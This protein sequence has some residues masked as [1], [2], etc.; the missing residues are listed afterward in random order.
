MSPPV[1]A[2]EVRGV[3]RF[4]A[5]PEAVFDAWLDP[6]AVGRWL[7]ATPTG[8]METVELDPRVGG[9]FTVSERRGDV[10]AE[11]FGTFVELDRPRRLVFDFATGRDQPLTR[12]TVDI[13][14][15]AGGCELTLSHRL[16]PAWAAYLDRARAGWTMVLDGLADAVPDRWEG[17]RDEG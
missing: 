9:A 5:S 7:F 4:G 6:A 12:V 8:V 3:R 16:D 2:A 11:H 1:E 15:V 14:P 17:M 13:R 10:L